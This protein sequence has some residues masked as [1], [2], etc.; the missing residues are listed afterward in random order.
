MFSVFVFACAT[1]CIVFCF[2]WGFIHG[3]YDG[4][5]DGGGD[6]RFAN[7]MNNLA[8]ISHSK[9]S[10]VRAE[11]RDRILPMAETQRNER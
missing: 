8:E 9:F 4:G 1:I 10:H 3:R 11:W 5:H 2:L 6:V 7:L